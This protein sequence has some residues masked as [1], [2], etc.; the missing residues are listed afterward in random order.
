[1]SFLRVQD[2]CPEAKCLVD[3]KFVKNM[4]TVLKP[5]ATLTTKL[6]A[7]QYIV[8]DFVRDYSIAIIELERIIRKNPSKAAVRMATRLKASLQ[9]REKAFDNPAYHAAL[10]LDPRFNNCSNKSRMSRAQRN[11]AIVSG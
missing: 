7:V 5:I 6:Q 1:M 11:S 10:Y 8:G 9:K 3:W 4:M 2:Y